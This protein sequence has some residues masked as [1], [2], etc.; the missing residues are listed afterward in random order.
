MS[1]E[2]SYFN[3][4]N[5]AL[6]M[7]SCSLQIFCSEEFIKLQASKLYLYFNNILKC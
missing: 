6:K 3:Q 1:A 4:I 7:T 2:S 5:M